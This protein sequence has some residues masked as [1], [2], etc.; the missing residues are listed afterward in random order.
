[1]GIQ[2]ALFGVVTLLLFAA[3]TLHELGHSLQALR[4]GVR[5]RDITLMPLGGVAQVE[6]MPEKPG[7]EFRIAIAG[8]L[9]NF[10]IAA[11]LCGVGIALGAR[12]IVTQRVD[13]SNRNW[14]GVA[15]RTVQQSLRLVRDWADHRV[16][17]RRGLSAA[18]AGDSQDGCAIV[19]RVAGRGS[20]RARARARDRGG[21]NA[22]FNR[23]LTSRKDLYCDLRYY[24]KPL[25]RNFATPQGSNRGRAR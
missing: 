20:C 2:G 23:G 12:A 25:D 8:P 7:Q 11:I 16:D 14:V 22:K 15:A 13:C 17:A 9:V 4:Y 24:H 19:N 1:M 3:V 21:Q 18:R 5:V 10:G 6:E